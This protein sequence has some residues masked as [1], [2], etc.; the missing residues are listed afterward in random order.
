M[1]KFS[2]IIQQHKVAAL[3]L[4]NNNPQN[5]QKPKQLQENSKNMTTKFIRHKF[6]HQSQLTR[7]TPLPQLIAK[8]SIL[9]NGHSLSSSPTSSKSLRIQQSPPMITRT[10]MMTPSP[11]RTMSTRPDKYYRT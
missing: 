8:S 5:E 2:R 7:S 10:M 11:M 3:K 9:T 4:N 6:A 1:S